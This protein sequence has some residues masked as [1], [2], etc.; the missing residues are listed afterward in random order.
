MMAQPQ[1]NALLDRMDRGEIAP[2]QAVETMTA[3]GIDASYAREV[4]F[5]ALGGSDLVETDTAG[6]ERYQPS[7]RL[8]SEVEAAL[9]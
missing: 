6:G 7:G 3:A 4:V 9:R 2:R 5:I 1:I 8:V